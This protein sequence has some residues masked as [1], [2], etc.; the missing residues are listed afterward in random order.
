[1]KYIVL[2]VAALAVI[3]L[4]AAAPAAVVPDALGA[5]TM[6]CKCPGYHD[7]ELKAAFPWTTSNGHGRVKFS[8]E[9]RSLTEW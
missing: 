7:E 6:C 1:M 2:L 4:T 9:S 3:G 8:L 5:E